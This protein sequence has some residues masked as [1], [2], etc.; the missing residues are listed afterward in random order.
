MYQNH[1]DVKRFTQLLDLKALV[2]EKKKKF[3]ETVTVIVCFC[4]C[5]EYEE[6]TESRRHAKSNFVFG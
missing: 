6:T 1:P 3:I 5:L 4:V 2:F